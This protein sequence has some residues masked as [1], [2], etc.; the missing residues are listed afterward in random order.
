MQELI[1]FPPVQL[2]QHLR[3][4]LSSTG[5]DIFLPDSTPNPSL[6]ALQDHDHPLF[7]LSR[8]KGNANGIG[9]VKLR[10][11]LERRSVLP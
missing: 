3:Q 6:A 9:N 2:P 10:V 11:P 8:L 7:N 1:N 4:Q 5:Q